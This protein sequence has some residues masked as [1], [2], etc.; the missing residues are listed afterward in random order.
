MLPWS[1][2]RFRQT[3]KFQAIKRGCTVIDVIEEYTSKIYT[4]CGQVHKK[5]GGSKVFR[6]RH[7]GHVI[8][9]DFNGALGNFLRALPDNTSLMDNFVTLLCPDSADASPGLMS[10]YTDVGNQ[11]LV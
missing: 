9:R 5:L 4:S 8:D 3:L 10:L 6:C 11:I 7:G 1:H 2:Y